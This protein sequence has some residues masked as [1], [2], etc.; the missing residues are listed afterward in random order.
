MAAYGALTS[1]STCCIAACGAHPSS[2]TCSS[3][4][5]HMQ[6]DVMQKFTV[7]AT[8]IVRKLLTD[9]ARLIESETQYNLG[10]GWHLFSPSDM[11]CVTKERYVVIKKKS[12]TSSDIHSHSYTQKFS[13]VLVLAGNDSDKFSLTER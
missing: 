4:K 12:A 11:L 9:E 5:H 1:N 2:T 13:T 7:L 6:S 3:F 8:T 10:M